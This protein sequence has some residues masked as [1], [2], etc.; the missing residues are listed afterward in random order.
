MLRTVEERGIRFVQLWFTDVLGTPKGF[1][2]TS[3]ELENALD[4]GMTFDGSAIDGFSRVQEADV[5]ARPDPTTFQLL[6]WHHDDAQV[7]RVFCDIA[8]L[9]G[10]PF[11]GDPRH[12]LRRTL[13]RARAAGFTFFASPEVEFFYFAD[14]DPAHGPVTLDSG[15]YFD[16][17]VADLTSD[18]RRRSVLMLEEMGIPVEHTQHEDARSQHEIDLRYTDALTMADTVMTTRMVIKEMARQEHVFAS[19]MPKPLA[20]VQ[21]SGMHTHISLWEGERNA[22]VDENDQYGLS[23]VARRFIAGLLHHAREITA[24]TNQWVN[25]Y[26]RLIGGYEAPVHVS[27]ARNNRSALVR[28]PVVK[29]GKTEST[30]LEYRAP[31]SA[32]NPYLTFA[33]ILAAGS[34]RPRRGLPAAAGGRRQPVHPD[35]QG[36]G[37]E[38][39]RAAAL[40]PARR[41]GRNGGLRAPGRHARG[42]RLRVVHPQQARGVG[43]LPGSGDPV[44]AGSLPASPLTP[45]G[46]MDPLLCF[47]SDLPAEVTLGLQSAGLGHQSVS[48]PDDVAAPGPDGRITGYSGALVVAGDDM[49]AAVA[50][51]RHLRL[52]EVPMTPLLLAI[53]TDQVGELLLR[54]DLYDDFCVLPARPEELVARLQHLFWR[55]GQSMRPDLIEYGP[56][57]LNLETYQAAVAGRVLDLTYMEYELLRFLAGHPAKVFTR[58]TLL[59]RVWGYEYYGGAR[60]VDV[61]IRRLRAKLGEEHAHLIQTV[62]SVGYRFGQVAWHPGVAQRNGASGPAPATGPAPTTAPSAQTTGT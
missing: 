21:G 27:W 24:V 54:D 26:K 45:S 41:R 5:L 39:D 38:G 61:H 9:D 19:F 57:M 50:F 28:V 31:D 2:I 15:S 46:P 43:R 18:L 12:A 1:N 59:S 55:T 20:G 47:P 23:E 30:R 62:R 6:P 25:S 37:Q 34:A 60:T 58:E 42:P 51:C 40:E 7:A 35:T 49:S 8:N 36:A 33:V 3:A 4:E 14:A 44:R 11:G 48:G 22:F 32:C 17:T 10:T 16:L 53:G 52:R 29:M 13:E 56:L